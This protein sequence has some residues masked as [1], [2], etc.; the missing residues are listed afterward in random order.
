LLAFLKRGPAL[1]QLGIA[2]LQPLLAFLK[3]GPAL[4]LLRLKHISTRVTV[5]L[6]FALTIAIRAVV[7]RVRRVLAAL[8]IKRSHA[9][10]NVQKMRLGLLRVR[11]VV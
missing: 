7:L 5:A 9:K 10:T 1:L 2:R 4:L 3:R 11:G 6:A 8:G